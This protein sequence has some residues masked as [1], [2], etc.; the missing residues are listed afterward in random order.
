MKKLLTAITV[1]SSISLSFA[2]EINKNSC[3]ET[4]ERAMRSD[5][6]REERYNYKFNR[7]GVVS[8]GGSPDTVNTGLSVLGAVA[9]GIGGA[10]IGAGAPV[11]I[12]LFLV[13][14]LTPTAISMIVNAPNREERA[15]ELIQESNKRL[16]RFTKKMQR[17]ISK[18]ITTA[19]VINAVQEGFD[20]G[21]FCEEHPKLMGPQEIRAHV[22]ASLQFAY[23]EVSICE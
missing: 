12:P 1:L 17:K 7:N 3:Q 5:N 6:L 19:D 13:G 22:E 8:V 11:M 16:E 21:K 10:L 18:N 9:G 4:Y 2:Q 14:A 23:G 15:L 20:S